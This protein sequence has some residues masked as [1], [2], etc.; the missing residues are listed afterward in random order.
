MNSLV[1]FPGEACFASSGTNVRRI[2]RQE[3]II[4]TGG[5]VSNVLVRDVKIRVPL[6]QGKE[7]TGANGVAVKNK[8]FWIVVGG[9]FNTRDSST[10]N[11]VITRDGGKSWSVPS[12]PP[13]G[14]RS[15]IE[16]LQKKQWITCGLNGVD[17][18]NDDGTTFSKISGEGFHVV[19]KAKKGKTVFLAGGGGRI[20]VMEP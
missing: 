16:Y 7:S 11:T 17:I 9:D 19:R 8:K 10:R 6:L 4:V 2:T 20:G 14:Y 12:M 5:L 18:T 15:C 1:A 3:A 13:G